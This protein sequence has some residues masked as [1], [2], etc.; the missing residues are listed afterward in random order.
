MQL[1]A[2]GPATPHVRG[3]RTFKSAT[4]P[5]FF[6][7]ICRKSIVMTLTLLTVASSNIS[8]VSYRKIA[9]INARY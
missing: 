3:H 7:T 5:V 4:V 2:F 1:S 9:S 6:C 8:V